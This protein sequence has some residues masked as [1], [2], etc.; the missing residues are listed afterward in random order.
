M[1]VCLFGDG[2]HSSTFDGNFSHF[3]PLKNSSISLMDDNQNEWGEEEP[4]D[5]KR[6][7]VSLLTLKENS[8]ILL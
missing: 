8:H 4:V 7:R 2:E 5:A 1:S 3:R 6:F